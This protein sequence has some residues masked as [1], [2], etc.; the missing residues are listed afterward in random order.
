MAYDRST[1]IEWLGEVGQSVHC[2][3]GEWSFLK[4]GG[5]LPLVGGMGA[6]WGWTEWQVGN[7]LSPSFQGMINYF[8]APTHSILCQ[9]SLF[10]NRFF[11]P[12]W[13]CMGAYVMWWRKSHH[14]Q[15]IQFAKYYRS[16]GKN[17]IP[18][19]IFHIMTTPYQLC[20]AQRPLDPPKPS[21]FCIACAA[22]TCRRILLCK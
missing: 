20:G 1:A 15:V 12:M 4:A 2:Q 9:I 10:C 7:V 19:L 13:Q 18:P 11:N 6:L 14:I 8:V 21:L 3:L 5:V 16:N 17:S 22:V